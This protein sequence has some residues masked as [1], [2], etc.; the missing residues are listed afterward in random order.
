LKKS[1]SEFNK[2]V[3]AVIKDEKK[4]VVEVVEIVE[5]ESYEKKYERKLSEFPDM[6]YF[7]DEELTIENDKLTELRQRNDIIKSMI[8]TNKEKLTAIGQIYKSNNTAEHYIKMLVYFGYL[9]QIE[10]DSD[11][12]SLD[13]YSDLDKTILKKHLNTDREKFDSENMKLEAMYI[14][15]DMK[16]QM[17]ARDHTV[18]TKLSNYMNNYVVEYTPLGE[19]WMRYNHCRGTFEYFSNHSIP[20]RFLEVVCRKYVMT[21]WCKPLYVSVEAELEKA[22]EKNNELKEKK[23]TKEKDVKKTN[24]SA[25]RTYNEA[26]KTSS[27]KKT[28]SILPPQLMNRVQTVDTNVNKE[29]TLLVKENANRYTW[30]GRLGD[31]DPL[32][33][34]NRS[35]VDKNAKLSFS[36]YKKLQ[37][38]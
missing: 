1:L 12:Y 19:V 8:E 21:Y 2:H 24:Y 32:K 20:Y 15:D 4:E 14:D 28:N 16:I 3:K 11:D 27:N 9:S 5:K 35:Y 31:F 17:K 29:K 22:K 37:I 23:E 34:I 13:D 10:V 33:K 36:D 30:Q 6:Y 38:K 18:G 25:I 7:T 26:I